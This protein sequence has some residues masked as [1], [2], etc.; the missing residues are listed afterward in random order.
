MTFH[1]SMH[2]VTSLSNIQSFDSSTDDRSIV[3]YFNIFKRSNVKFPI[4]SHTTTRGWHDPVPAMFVPW[5]GARSAA[6]VTSRG[7]RRGLYPFATK[8]YIRKPH[9]LFSSV[10]RLASPCQYTTDRP[11]KPQFSPL[12]MP[13]CVAETWPQPKGGGAKSRVVAIGDAAPHVA[14]P[15]NGG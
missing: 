11:T 9:F 14:L 12:T 13:C 10:F 5:E 7:R 3:H 8:K 6:A 2:L 15:R 4:A 1:R